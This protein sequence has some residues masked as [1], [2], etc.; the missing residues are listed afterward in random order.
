MSASRKR[1]PP[2]WTIHL[3]S[4]VCADDVWS[5]TDV[6]VFD[7]DEYL[8]TLAELRIPGNCYN[9]AGANQTERFFKHATRAEARLLEEALRDGRFH[10]TPIPNMLNG[11]VYTLATCPLLLEPYRALC[12]RV[13]GDHA[14]SRDAYHMESP[15]WTN[16][17]VNLLACAGFRSFSK[18]LL[19]YGAP[20]VDILRRDLPRLLTLE[21]APGRVVFLLLG[22]GHYQEGSGALIGIQS[23]WAPKGFDTWNAQLEQTIIP[24]HA[25]PAYPYPVRDIALIGCYGDLL[26]DTKTLAPVKAKAIETANQ[27][28]QGYRVVNSTFASFFDAVET[29][30]GPASEARLRRVSGDTGA[31]W[32][33]WPNTAQALWSEVRQRMRDVSSLLAMDALAQHDARRERWLQT[34]VHELVALGDHAWNGNV[35]WDMPGVKQTNLAIRRRR[36]GALNKAVEHVRRSLRPGRAALAEGQTLTLVNTLPWQ[37]PAM[38]TLPAGWTLRD[39]TTGKALPVRQGHVRVPTMRAWE[40]RRMIVTRAPREIHAYAGFD[41][42]P[43][44][45]VQPVLFIGAEAISAAFD[46]EAQSWTLGPYRVSLTQRDAAERDVREWVFTV[47]GTPPEADY[48][49]C[50]RFDL[51]W[52]RCEWRGESGGGFVMPG[53]TRMGGDSLLGIAGSIFSAGEGLSARA[54]RGRQR[55]DFAFDES[56][57]CGLGQRTTL[58][59]R[60]LYQDAPDEALMHACQMTGTETQGALFWYL[61]SNQQNYREALPDQAGAR[62]WRFRCGVRVAQGDFEDAALYRFAAGFN[63]EPEIVSVDALEDTTDA[64]RVSPASVLVLG[65]RR[66]NGTIEIDLYNTAKAPVRAQLR[67]ALVDSG[68]LMRADMLGFSRRALK[69]RGLELAPLEFAKVLVTPG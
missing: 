55:I 50:I 60:G 53:P 42:Q 21:V 5:A 38:L 49:L 27:S 54:K 40:A 22:C 19:H 62:Q 47:Q 67:G 4:D 64:I 57:F 23:R 25:Q 8:T 56:G 35:E 69:G 6:E 3:I 32:D 29:T 44:K 68:K 9:F 16:G 59:A 30:L 28:A 37:R 7:R 63:R 33:L 11:G 43:F 48:E 61:L 12:K 58:F 65:C 31:S 41:L 2:H 36:L 20:W 24:A 39:P 17:L 34:A 45:Q 51:P 26:P 15:T 1:I 10:C 46:A 18:T 13:N 52:A 14:L 66:R